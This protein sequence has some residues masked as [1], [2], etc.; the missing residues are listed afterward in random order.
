MPEASHPTR[1]RPRA[2]VRWR[3]RFDSFLTCFVPGCRFG[4]QRCARSATQWYTHLE[5]IYIGQFV[6]LRLNFQVS[7][8]RSQSFTR[9]T[10]EERI[11]CGLRAVLGCWRNRSRRSEWSIACADG[12]AGF[13][14]VD[15]GPRL[16]I[17]PDRSHVRAGERVEIFRV[18]R[19]GAH[20][21]RARKPTRPTHARVL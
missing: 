20:A 7:A 15:Y 11:L 3:A 16:R 8:P 12:P 13:V 17:R 5:V 10:C 9:A 2:R 1:S 18:D 21:P 6:E 14:G 19:R 4:S